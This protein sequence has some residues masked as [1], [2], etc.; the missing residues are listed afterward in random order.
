MS[1]EDD[2]LNLQGVLPD[3]DE[4][5]IA[6]KLKN[7]PPKD[8]PLRCEQVLMQIINEKDAIDRANVQFEQQIKQ[9]VQCVKRVLK[10]ISED[11][12]KDTLYALGPI[13]ER[14]HAT[15]RLLLLQS[16]GK[17]ELDRRKRKHLEQTKVR[18]CT[19]QKITP[20][21]GSVR[22]TK[23]AVINL[24]DSLQR[25]T[26]A[27]DRR[28]LKGSLQDIRQN[29]RRNVHLL[30]GSFKPATITSEVISLD[31]TLKEEGIGT[32]NAKTELLPV[33]VTGEPASTVI[34]NQ[35]LVSNTPLEFLPSNSTV[36]EI[37]NG[38]PPSAS[39]VAEESFVVDEKLFLKVV[40][41]FP[42]ACPRYIRSL[43][44]G[45][46]WTDQALGEI[47]DLIFSADQYPMRPPRE[48]SPDAQVDPEEQLK[49]VEEVLPDA[50]P[51]YLR[52]ML[53]SFS[54]SKEVLRDFINDA[55]ENGSYPTRKEYLR[56]QQ[57]SAQ[58]KQYTTEFNI[59][60]FV[61][62]FKDPVAY[63]EDPK[64][65]ST[66]VDV[67]DQ[68]YVL[69]YMR[70]RY[71]RLALKV[72]KQIVV[73]EGQKNIFAIIRV[74]E[75]LNRVDA[76]VQSAY[77]NKCERRPTPIPVTQIQNIPLLQELAYFTH[78]DEI[79]AFL[80]NKKIR[81]ELERQNAK[82]LGLFETCACCYNE[83]VMPK[84]VLECS[85]GCRFCRECVRKGA[86]IAFADGKLQ[87]DC[88]ATCGGDFSLQTLQNA[89]PSNVFSKI[90]QKKAVAEVQAVGMED[91]ETCPFC[92]FASIPAPDDR[93]FRCFNPDC[94]KESCRMCKEMSH[95]PLRCE[96]VEKDEAVRARTYIENKMTEALIRECWKCKNKFIK[97]E[98]CNKMTC[99]CGASMCYICRQPVKDYKHFNGL[100]GD[101][102]QL[103]PLYVDNFTVNEANVIRAAKQAK[104]E[105]DPSKLMQDPTSD[106]MNF[107]GERIKQRNGELLRPQ[108]MFRGIPVVRNVLVPLRTLAGLDANWTTMARRVL[109]FFNHAVGIFP[110]E[111][112]N[113]R[114]KFVWIV[115]SVVILCSIIYSIYDVVKDADIL[116]DN[117]LT[118]RL[119]LLYQ[120]FLGTC[121]TTITVTFT[122][123]LEEVISI[124]ES[125]RYLTPA[126]RNLT[127][128][129]AFILIFGGYLVHT[130][131]TFVFNK[132]YPVD[133][134]EYRMSI[135]L[136]VL[137]MI[138][139]RYADTVD[140]FNASVSK[141]ECHTEL[142]GLSLMYDRTCDSVEKFNSTYG[143][144]L[145][146]MIF[147][148]IFS[149]LF[150]GAVILVPSN[151]EFK[152]SN[153]VYFACNLF[154]VIFLA[155]AG[156]RLSNETKKT[157]SICY[158]LM[159]NPVKN[160]FLA[161]NDNL[162]FVL[163]QQ[164]SY[165][166]PEISAA[167]FFPI[168]HSMLI[169]F[170][171]TVCSYF[172]VVVQF[173]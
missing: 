14:K 66:M 19:N 169:F 31:D 81:D 68:F 87:F 37:V 71:K 38:G 150:Y 137:T 78:K 159:Q 139:N 43:C 148:L 53:Q 161:S 112:L 15:V 6:I 97:E 85:S 92:D 128:K 111:R 101:Q 32:F 62:L 7:A 136:F 151:K 172:I 95:I 57:I 50:D 99:S 135:A 69:A 119:F 134:S 167:G 44:Y 88:F 127:K 72:I 1:F 84:D 17:S 30:Q 121:N 152:I 67:R 26:I 39:N 18:K 90:A 16:S 70:N 48:P 51:S 110:T 109:Y 56:K 105:I 36:S 93:L 83:Q 29:I 65:R 60:N 166:R 98:G 141:V 96:E 107:F 142:R 45:K 158:S 13:R 21:D 153:T 163:A 173:L 63:F 162:L 59:E 27:A 100:G 79:V 77:V 129:C 170:T 120:L 123:W 171:S 55:V 52:A 102:H 149:S 9:D 2:Q 160:H 126:R 46:I 35:P 54:S 144:L 47:V 75:H 34:N 157:A 125:F 154:Q 146:T 41:L 82:E 130:V 25:P 94:M 12:I 24:H 91:L 124:A 61:R 11:V 103:C 156:E 10:N 113:P 33:E 73:Q 64:R 118:S 3:I 4:K 155:R 42:N 115:Y 168:N 28:K 40:E 5:E 117:V 132:F 131:M 8:N 165:R 86:E 116:I 89:L 138:V 20:T 147:T 143:P 23:Q 104:K 122:V 133:L 108:Q 145:F 140:S 164:A 74:L 106:L 114:K 76:R 58:Q 22:H 80:E 49:M